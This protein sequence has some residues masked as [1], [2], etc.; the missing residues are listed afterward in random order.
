MNT[1]LSTL[2]AGPITYRVGDPALTDGPYEFTEDP[3]CS[4][5]ETVAL[6]N[7]PGW[8]QHNE[9]TSDFTIPKTGDLSI[10][11][12]HVVTILGEILVP[13]DYTKST[14]TPMTVQYDFSIFVEPCVILD[15]IAVPIRTIVYTI[16]SVAELSET[17]SFTQ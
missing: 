16:G 9:G 17:Y 1:Y 2:N 10:I 5:P 3:V 15:F 13:D 12:E 6:T 11:G 14:Y 8:A 7:L 4:Y